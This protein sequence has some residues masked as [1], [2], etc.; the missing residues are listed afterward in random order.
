MLNHGT[1]LKFWHAHFYIS[2]ISVCQPIST[3]STANYYHYDMIFKIDEKIPAQRDIN[4]PHVHA[5]P[6]DPGTALRTRTQASFQK[7]RK[8]TDAACQIQQVINRR[9]RARMLYR[10]F[11]EQFFDA[12][13][14]YDCGVFHRRLK[15]RPSCFSISPVKWDLS[16][17]PVKCD[18]A[19]TMRTFYQFQEQRTTIAAVVVMGIAVPW[20]HVHQNMQALRY[21][22]EHGDLTLTRADRKYSLPRHKLHTDSEARLVDGRLLV[23]IRQMQS[24]GH[25]DNQIPSELEDANLE[26]NCPHARETFH[27]PQHLADET[28]EASR[29]LCRDERNRAGFVHKRYRCKQCPTETLI[30]VVRHEDFESKDKVVLWPYILCQS[31]YIDFGR[32]ESPDEIEWKALS[33]WPEARPND[34]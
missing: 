23:R 29:L 20:L 18:Y 7:D 31:R 10:R 32:C 33:T 21:S 25:F 30:E 17:S 34:E 15:F 3:V 14:C 28:V 5:T 26:F 19:S 11:G 16:T 2:E 12:L 27:Y 22:K 6:E 1:A 13:I 4:C 8:C 9:E 24:I